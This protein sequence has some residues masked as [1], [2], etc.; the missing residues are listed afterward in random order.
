MWA[1][2]GANGPQLPFSDTALHCGAAP[3]NRPFA[4]GAKFCKQQIHTVRTDPSF[5]IAPCVMLFG[6][7]P[8]GMRQ[9]FLARLDLTQGAPLGRMLAYGAKTH[10]VGVDATRNV[11]EL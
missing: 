3:S 8:S 6:E 11:H 7:N 2:L 10:I 5:D 4:A 9:K 1:V